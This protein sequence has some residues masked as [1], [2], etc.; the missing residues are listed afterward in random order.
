[1][2]KQNKFVKLAAAA[3]LVWMVSATTVNAQ[4]ASEKMAKDS[5]KNCFTKGEKIVDN[6]PKHK[7][8][9][10]EQKILDKTIGVITNRF[11]SQEDAFTKLDKDHNCQLDRSEVSRLLSYAKVSGLVRTI[12][13][14]RLITRYDLSHDGT[15]Q[16]EE[17]HHAIDL[18][19]AQQPKKQSKKLPAGHSEKHSATQAKK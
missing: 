19:L 2:K 17:F 1:M 14:G 5:H 4:D 10:R 9:K 16:W 18:A 7:A 15:V 6:N 3:I 12:A 11:Q 8:S 13:S